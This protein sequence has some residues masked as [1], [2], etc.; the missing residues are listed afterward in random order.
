MNLCQ[1]SGA[2]LVLVGDPEQL[3]SIEAG[4]AFRNVLERNASAAIT[5]VRRQKTGW[6]RD[7]TMA[8]SQGNTADALHAYDKH[9]CIYRSKSRTCAKEHLVSD[10]MQAHKRAPDKSRLVLAYSRKDV[11]DL[12]ELIKAKMVQAGNVSS[13]NSIIAVTVQ[14][15]DVERTQKQGFAMGDRIMF[16][17]N[18]ST[19]GVMNGTFGTLT[20][21]EDGHFSVVLDSSRTISFSPAEYNHLQL[22][23][24]ATI[25]KSQGMTVDESYVLATPHFDRHTTY[26]AMSRHKE[27]VK[28]YAST[29]DFKNQ[30][31]LC[32]ALGKKGETLST[33]DFTD[34]QHKK[35]M[36]KSKPSLKQRIKESW[37]R[38]R[39]TQ[40]EQKPIATKPPYTRPSIAE[41]DH[42]QAQKKQRL[43]TKP[44]TQQD[45]AKLRDE[46]MKN[47]AP[48]MPTSHEREND[49]NLHPQYER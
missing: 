26:V 36:Q 23:Y 31:S 40:P 47:A 9:R 7:A 1:Q 6:Q 10:V 35:A 34:P 29:R 22:G 2:K 3:Q 19:M 41:T 45:F 42:V 39:N 18:D 11:T 12:N 17:K 30:N 28:L 43:Q 48:V 37:Q 44:L 4:A 49:R 8:L 15:G 32:R 20:Q 25:H 14:N 5:E 38:V 16:R 21:I 46:Y 24:A 13:S 33:L 27:N